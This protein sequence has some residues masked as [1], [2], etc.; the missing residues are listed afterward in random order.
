MQ[1][2]KEQL[3]QEKK[4]FQTS[5]AQAARQGIEYLRQDI[6]NK[7][8]NPELDKQIASAASDPKLI[9]EIIAA[10]VKAVEKHGPSGDLIAYIPKSIS[11][12]AVN[13][14]LLNEVVK[15]LKNGKVEI[16]NFKGGAQ[17]KLVDKRM[18]ID[19]SDEALQELL[20]MFVRKDFR[21]FIFGT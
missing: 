21:K 18:T 20:S 7:L 1:K 10:L 8:F 13:A 12:Q 4:V 19:M 5:L 2:A 14:L 17:L 9:A 3:D 16:G 11:P 15:K 6:E